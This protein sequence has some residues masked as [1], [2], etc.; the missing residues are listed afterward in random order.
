MP[1]NDLELSL[2][3]FPQRWDG[4]SNLLSVN[5][6]LL[7]VGDPTAPLGTGPIFAGTTVHVN[8]N[9]VAGLA[10]L[11]SSTTTPSQVAAFTAQPPAVAGT[12][13]T[14]LYKQLVANNI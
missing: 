8:A 12:L 9:I 7:P 2:M 14:T 4:S 13:Y 1:L 3:A 10:T 11:P 5:L 6:L